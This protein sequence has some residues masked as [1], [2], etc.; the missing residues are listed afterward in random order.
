KRDYSN[1]ILIKLG[2]YV[3]LAGSLVDTAQFA[4]TLL[5]IATIVLIAIIEIV[6][7]KRLKPSKVSG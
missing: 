6:R 3:V 2:K 4:M 7:R 5:I 1:P